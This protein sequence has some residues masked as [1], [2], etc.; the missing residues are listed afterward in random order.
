MPPNEPAPTAPFT[1]EDRQELEMLVEDTEAV[2]NLN[3]ADLI[4]RAASYITHLEG[5]LDRIA[6]A[7]APAQHLQEIARA[8]IPTSKEDAGLPVCSECKKPR[9]LWAGGRCPDCTQLG[10]HRPAPSPSKE[11]G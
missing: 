9:E 5:A 8:S 4:G 1:D 2:P 3:D 6:T 7:H 11:D 10:P